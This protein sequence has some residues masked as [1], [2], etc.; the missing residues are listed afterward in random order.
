MSAFIVSH[1]HIDALMTYAAF[2]RISYWN[3][4][5][6][7][8]TVVTNINAEEVGR[9]LLH[10]N[11]RSVRHRYSDFGPDDLPGTIGEDA[12][13]YHFRLF[14]RSLTAIQAIKAVN[15]LEYQSCEHDDWEGSL[16]W[17]ICQAIKSHATHHLPGYD[18][19]A[20]EINRARQSA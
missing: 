16:A 2:S 10:E 11:E 6:R 20:W 17:R 5:A 8:R 13:S 9:I 18:L 12:A 7:D 3:P 1:D 19:A 15:C 14:Q 4:E